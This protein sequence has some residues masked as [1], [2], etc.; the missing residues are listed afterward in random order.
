MK[1]IVQRIVFTL[2]VVV[3]ALSA[4]LAHPGHGTADGHGAEHYMTSP[5]HY[6][7]YLV[8]AAGIIYLGYKT[9]VSQKN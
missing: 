6:F 9:Y 2:G 5:L 3:S 7:G 1:K 4:T 8:L